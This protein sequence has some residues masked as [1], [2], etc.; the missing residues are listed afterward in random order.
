M[1]KIDISFMYTK[2]NSDT[3]FLSRL[4]SS[5]TKG[6]G[7][8]KNGQ[9]ILAN[10]LFSFCILTVDRFIKYNQVLIVPKDMI[11]AYYKRF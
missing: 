2:K 8:K 5:S 1:K 9:N 3:E 11:S 6:V 7:G 10:F 4:S